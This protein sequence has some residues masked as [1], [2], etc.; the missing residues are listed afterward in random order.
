MKLNHEKQIQIKAGPILICMIWLGW[1]GLIFWFSSKPAAVSQKQSHAVGEMV[2]SVLV[3]G[4]QKWSSAK[5]LKEAVLID[6]FIRKT[7]HFTEYTILGILTA[8]VRQ[9]M[10]RLRSGKAE[11]DCSAFKKSLWRAS[12]LPILWCS[13]YASSDE[14]HQLFVP[15][16]SGRWQDV[17]LD[18]AGALTGILLTGV[19]IRRRKK[20]F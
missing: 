4:Y 20:K 5:Q 18:S 17:L 12:S 13:L 10:Y 14:F 19:L 2:C 1:M 11:Q 6:H 15:G 3:S 8:N 7:A 9:I 16:R